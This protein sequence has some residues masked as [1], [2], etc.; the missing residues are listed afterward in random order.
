[1]IVLPPLHFFFSGWWFGTWL[2]FVHSVGNVIIPTGELIFFRGV[3]IPPATHQLYISVFTYIYTYKYIQI[4]I[5]IYWSLLTIINHQFP[6]S[7]PRPS[8]YSSDVRNTLGSSPKLGDPWPMATEIP[9]IYSGL[10][11]TFLVDLLSINIRM[12]PIRYLFVQREMMFQ[13]GWQPPALHG[14]NGS[15]WKPQF[16][17]EFGAKVWGN[18]A[19]NLPVLCQRTSH[20]CFVWKTVWAMREFTHWSG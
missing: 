2:V 15:V 6:N 5:F 11:L 17:G 1:M 10:E 19:A 16:D 18:S 7:I 13:S 14:Y 8:P 3:G 20:R 12:L 4:Y 9:P